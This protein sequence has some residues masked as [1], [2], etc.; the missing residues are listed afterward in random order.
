MSDIPSVLSNPP[1]TTDTRDFVFESSQLIG[2]GASPTNNLYRT[3]W[4][5]Y[6]GELY[7]ADTRI[8]TLKVN[9]TPADINTFNFT[10]TVMVKNRV[11]RVNKI[12]YKPNSLAKVE[13]ILMP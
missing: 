4:Q 12:E 10:D 7:N 8:M 3:Y 6:F 1:A 11:F 13:F 5:P 2:L 9:L